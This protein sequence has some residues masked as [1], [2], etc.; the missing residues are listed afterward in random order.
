MAIGMGFLT[1]LLVPS[2]DAWLVLSL[3]VHRIEV[4][5]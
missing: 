5:R 3:S 4:V 1:R 2:D